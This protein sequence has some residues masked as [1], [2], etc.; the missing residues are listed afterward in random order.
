VF[1]DFLQLGEDVECGGVGFFQQ[2]S[3]AESNVE[4]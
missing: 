3:I 2:S 4:D 1:T